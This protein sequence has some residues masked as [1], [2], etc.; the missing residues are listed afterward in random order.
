[1]VVARLSPLY[2]LLACHGST[3]PQ[4]AAPEV[5]SHTEFGD[6]DEA[7]PKYD[8]A[9]LARVLAA[10]R[11]AVAAV[12]ARRDDLDETALA[13]LA[14][15]RRFV[16]SLETCS[17][18]HVR[19]PPRLDDPPWSADPDTPRL[20]SKLRFDLDDW[21]AL[22]HELHGRACACRTIECVDSLG[23]TIDA[24]EKRPMPQVEADEAASATITR[25]REC[26]FRLRG[27][28]R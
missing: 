23:F 14:V 21:R 12:E 5:A 18:Q 2:L 4:H 28:T 24:L 22:A 27:R 13:D 10:E 1:M 20:D 6:L 17:E 3:P 11:D 19:C 9:E 25:A 16:A 26:L 7:A 8:Q 15:H